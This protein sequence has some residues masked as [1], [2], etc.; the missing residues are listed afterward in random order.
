[1]RIFL[2]VLLLISWNGP[3]WA[4]SISLWTDVEVQKNGQ[5]LRLAWAGGL[6]EPQIS[7]AFLDEDSLADLFVFDRSG[8]QVLTFLATQTPQG[9]RYVSA[10]QLQAAFPPLKDFALL[11]DMNCDGWADICTANEDSSGIR[12]WFRQSNGALTFTLGS[13]LLKSDVGTIFIPGTDIPGIADIDQDGRQDIL[14][15]DQAGDYIRWYRRTLT[16]D[17]DSL[18]FVLQDDCWGKFREAGLSND[19]ILDADCPRGT[20]AGGRH[21]GSTICP[22]DMNGDA[23]FD[24][25]LGDLNASNL[26]GLTNGGS[27]MAADMIAAET[28]FPANS[29]PASFLQFP[30]AFVLDANLDQKPDLLVAPNAQGISLNVHNLW[31]YQ[32][33]GTASTHSYTFSQYDFLGGQMIDHGNLSKPAWFDYNSDG[34]PDLVIGNFSRRDEQQSYGSTLSLWE[35]TGTAETP[36]FSWITDDYL[37]LSQLFNPSIF[38]M[39]PSFGDLDGDGDEDMLIGDESG[40]LH[41][42]ENVAGLGQVA[43]FTIKQIQFAGID[44]GGDA[45]PIIVDLNRDGLPDLLV[46]EKSGN[47]NYFENTG[48]SGN[49]VFATNNNQIGAVDVMPDCCSGYSVPGIFENSSG[50]YELWVGSEA[51]TLFH[52]EDIEGNL[53]GNWTLKTSDAGQISVGNQLSIGLHQEAAGGSIW[54]AAGNS[55]GG[56]S[57]FKT[58]NST[59]NRDKLK[60]ETLARLASLGDGTDILIRHETSLARDWHISC[61]DLQGKVLFQSNWD[62]ADQSFRL[63]AYPQAKGLYVLIISNPT[64]IKQVLK[65]LK[66]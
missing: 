37:S 12:V 25:L 19:I 6:N 42:L 59:H 40:K 4:Q 11:R 45:A 22:V 66:D 7:Q 63:P 56:I 41:W 32:N 14:S 62:A 9:L 46:G 29:L 64:G 10:P 49:P 39:H 55:R 3:A 51:G 54:V 16:Q 52:Y 48:T 18:G 2:F 60:T 65:W 8:S 33:T 58:G 23:A 24:L 57:L 53:G 35:N 44:V 17:C 30:A 43:Q 61:Q 27:S 34:L 21:A 5:S 15:F 26:V 38:G 28:Q 50:E 36:A 1:M 31:Y 47:L 20:T 13:D